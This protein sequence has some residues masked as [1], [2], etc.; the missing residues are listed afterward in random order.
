M[1][2]KQNWKS[3]VEKNYYKSLDHQWMTY[4]SEGRKKLTQQNLLEEI[5]ALWHEKHQSKP[6]CLPSDND[7][8]DNDF[9][10]PVPQFEFEFNDTSVIE[11]VMELMII[12]YSDQLNY[13]TKN[14]CLAE[15][16]IRYHLSAILGLAPL[17]KK[18]ERHYHHHQSHMESKIQMQSFK[19]Y[20]HSTFIGNA[21]FYYLF[22]Y[23]QVINKFINN[24]NTIISLLNIYLFIY[25]D[26]L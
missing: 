20:P 16:F 13:G 8:D 12:S 19:Y 18:K 6:I 10:S 24:N 11:D 25:I 21:T 1:E 3:T 4:K 2:R 14:T 22:R 15:N 26:G 5:S 7:N 17:L 23:F 9:L